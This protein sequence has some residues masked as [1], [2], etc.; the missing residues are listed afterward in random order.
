MDSRAMIEFE[1]QPFRQR[2]EQH[3]LSYLAAKR[4]GSLTGREG[5]GPVG[6]VMSYRRLGSDEFADVLVFGSN[7]YLG[8]SDHPEVKARVIDAVRRYGTGTGGSPAF[9]GYTRQHRELEER[10][11]ALGGHDDALLLPGGYMANLC[12]VNGLMGR[13]DILVFDKNSHASVV[14][15]VK[16]AGVRFYTFDPDR[17]DELDQLLVHVREKAAANAQI[18]TTI[19]GVRSTDGAIADLPRFVAI[20]ERHDAVM[21]LDD[22]HGLGTVGRRGFGTIEH[23][24]LYGRIHVRMSTCSKALGAQGAFVSGAADLISLLRSRAFPYLF[25]SGLAQPTIAAIAAAL[26]VLEREPERVA[27]LHANVGLAQELLEADGFRIR[28]GA[29]G[30]VP[31]FLDGRDGLAGEMNRWLFERGL[32]VNVMEFPMVPPG[33]ERLRLSL[34]STH[35]PDQIRTAVGMIAAA[36]AALG[37][38]AREIE[39]ICA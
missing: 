22:A 11:A 33:L 2:V 20:S 13:Q 18:F 30:I 10:L 35:E 38:P 12:W 39:E 24:D 21:V 1:R 29:S 26:D 27:R 37:Q 5:L 9:S 28:R 7:S 4:R 15:A 8:L 34:M 14:N 17:L 3:H 6:N 31:V 32:F 25:T 16:M 36:R 23:H 19:E